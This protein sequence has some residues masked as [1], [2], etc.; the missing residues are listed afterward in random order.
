MP[1]CC[2]KRKQRHSLP[3][4]RAPVG[5]NP[6]N[7]KVEDNPMPALTDSDFLMCRYMHPNRGTHSVVGPTVFDQPFLGKQ[8]RRVKNGHAFYYGQRAGGG[9][10]TFL[11]HRAD[12][13]LQP[14]WYKPVEDVVSGLVEL[15]KR[16]APT[17][18]VPERIKLG[19]RA[20]VEASAEKPETPATDEVEA[21]L[22][23]KAERAFDPQLIPGISKRTARLMV[24]FGVKS[25]ADILA[26]GLEGLQKFDGVGRTK[27]ELII[28]FLKEKQE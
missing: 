20:S 14:Q 12:A 4:Y 7:R 23:A 17:P 27:A 1:G 9:T 13:E 10:E 24:E 8:M 19:M 21:L 28:G 11:V 3:R 26:L 22:K 18:P 15:P 16:K 2:G 5:G 25:E 6:H